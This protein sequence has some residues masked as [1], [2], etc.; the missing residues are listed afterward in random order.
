MGIQNIGVLFPDGFPY[1]EESVSE[2]VQP[3]SV[4]TPD[5]NG[6]FTIT[7]PSS[8]VMITGEDEFTLNAPQVTDHNDGSYTA[9]SA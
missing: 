1:S 7:G 3:F 6:V 5:S 4:G 9:T 8:Q 2:T